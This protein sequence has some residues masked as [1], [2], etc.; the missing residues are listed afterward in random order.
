MQ[1][2]AYVRDA[3]ESI[4]ARVSDAAK[5]ANR[6]M[7]CVVAV[8]KSAT[9][10][11]VVALLETGLITHVAENRVQCY[12]ARKDMMTMNGYQP[13]CHLIGS[14]QTNK[15]KYIAGHV[16]LIQS[17]DS[18]RL[19]AEIEKQSAKRGVVQDCLVEV[20]SGREEA[21]GGVL[22]EDVEAFLHALKAYPHIC[23]K[24]LMTMAPVTDTPEMAR[25]YFRLTKQLFD[26]LSSDGFFGDDPILSMGMSHSFEVAIEEGATMVRVGRAFF[27][28]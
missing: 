15:V 25:P 4:M 13:N 18:E 26:T 21:K 28:G 22:P 8:T 16:S 7:P 14:L 12:M 27:H 3:V 6:P 20:N 11:E 17:L 9:D 19:A 2:Y 24:G 23:V 1:D 10:A 5:R